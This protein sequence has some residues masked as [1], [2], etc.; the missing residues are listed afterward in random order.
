MQVFK[1]KEIKCIF[2]SFFSTWAL[3]KAGSF[4]SE[5]V[6]TLVFFGLCYCFFGYAR[7]LL[8]Q[9][10]RKKR[11]QWMAG[12]LAGIFTVLVLLAKGEGYVEELSAPLFRIGILL[13]VAIGFWCLFFEMLCVV[14]CWGCHMDKLYQKFCCPKSWQGAQF[15]KNHFFFCSFLIC[16]L[17][18]LPYFL[19][20]F[21]GIMT[22]DS[23]NQME[24]ATGLI[25][26]SNHHPWAH[27][28][29][30][31]LFYTVGYALTGSR[32]IAM[33]C[34]TLLQMVVLA[35][36]VSYFA[37]TMKQAG[38]KRVYCFLVVLS[39][40]L[41]PFHAVFSVTVW[42]DIPFAAGILLLLTALWRNQINRHWSNYV[43]LGLGAIVMCLF[44]SNGWYAF[45]LC[46]P[47]FLWRYWKEDRRVVL[48]L[49][50]VL[51]VAALVRGPMMSK[52]DVEGPDFVESLSIPV[53]QVAS[54]LYNGRELTLE[55]EE[56][57]HRVADVTYVKQ[58]YVPSFADNMKE[59]VRA[60][61]PEYLEAHK[62]DYFRLWV[63]LGIAYPG[64]YLHAYIEQTRGYW[65]PDSFYRV[66]E[67]EGIVESELGI[68]S[69]PLIGGPVIV[70]AKELALKLE[71]VIP[72]YGMLWSM[73]TTFWI[74]LVALSCVLIRGEKRKLIYFLPCLVLWGTVMIATPVSAEFRYVYFLIL[75][76]PFYLVQMIIRERN[77]YP[78]DGNCVM[79]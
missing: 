66:A 61:H 59:L 72:I 42:K 39:Y 31:Q 50:G 74:F 52:F 75:C 26:Y 62:R 11:I 68:Y 65:E 47:F 3:T 35:L 34:Y 51:A 12:I 6:L 41:L 79:M 16:I 18:W 67:A 29:V 21:P 28:L 33:G 73:G 1:T 60:G 56:L 55:Q 43:A 5:S 77:G 22:P 53:Q 7:G 27:T 17:C 8:A 13:A 32:V 45:L 36:S 19:Y 49:T 44:R 78:D 58:M 54:V 25:P 40:G 4:E 24:Q 69:M 10:N 46:F 71:S 48:T 14:F 30:M 57:I 64:D 23:V 38:V 9:E 2:A 76:L 63:E 20:H 70:K 37:N 15:Y